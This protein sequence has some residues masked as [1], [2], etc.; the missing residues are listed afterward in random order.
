[1]HEPELVDRAGDAGAELLLVETRY[2]LPR[3]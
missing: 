2:V 1:V 3:T